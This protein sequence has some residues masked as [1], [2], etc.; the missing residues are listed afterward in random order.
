MQY[1]KLGLSVLGILSVSA[2]CTNP[3]TPP[4]VKVVP[5][6]SCLTQ[7]DLLP[8]PVDGSDLSIRRWEYLSTEEFGKCRR[9][10]KDCVEWNS[11]T[12]F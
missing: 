12:V 5:P 6:A 8:Y 1:V 4:T 3:S 9:L 10:H 2:C 7:C 11:Q